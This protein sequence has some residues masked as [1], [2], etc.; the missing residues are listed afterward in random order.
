MLAIKTGYH[1]HQR[2]HSGDWTVEQFIRMYLKG[3]S[4]RGHSDMDSVWNSPLRLRDGM[5]GLLCSKRRRH[6]SG[7]TVRLIPDYGRYAIRLVPDRT[8]TDLICEEIYD[9]NQ[10]VAKVTKKTIRK[11]DSM[12]SNNSF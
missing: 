4:S 1:T 7:S 5:F 12:P 11:M 3:M 10:A 2:I 6:V 9:R 8:A